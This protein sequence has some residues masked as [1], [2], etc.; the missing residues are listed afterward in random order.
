MYLYANTGLESAYS[1]LFNVEP[2]LI[3]AGATKQFKKK[4]MKMEIATK[5]LTS[6]T[7]QKESK[8]LILAAPA[9]NFWASWMFRSA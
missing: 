3:L 4:L 7:I 2:Q 5:S 6:I 1:L 8:T 9:L